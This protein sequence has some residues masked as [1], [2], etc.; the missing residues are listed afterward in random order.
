[1]D[2]PEFLPLLFSVAYLLVISLIALLPSGD[3]K[4]KSMNEKLSFGIYDKRFVRKETEIL[5]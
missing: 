3:R 1:M 2:Y 5:N 4:G